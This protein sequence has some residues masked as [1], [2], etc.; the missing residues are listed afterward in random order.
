MTGGGGAQSPARI[1]AGWWKMGLGILAVILIPFALFGDYFDA[2]VEAVKGVAGNPPAVFGLVV[3]LLI[4]DV[5]LPVPSSIL[6]VFAGYGLGFSYGWL[7]GWLGLNGG[8]LLGYWLGKQSATMVGRRVLGDDRQ[9]ELQSL[10]ARWGVWVIAM[11]RPVPVLAEAAAYISGVSGIPLRTV[12]IVG[13]LANAGLAAA[14]AAAGAY[15]ADTD[16]LVV[17]VV[18]SVVLPALCTLL[19]RALTA[20]RA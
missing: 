11:T 1:R 4:V 10:M 9:L 20:R 15:A 17:A 18:A 6:L 19:W 3:S 2:A 5:L 13:A 7:A 14:M 8:L 12:L 16:G